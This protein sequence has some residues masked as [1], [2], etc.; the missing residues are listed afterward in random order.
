VNVSQFWLQAIQGAVIV[1]AIVSD[2]IIRTR[3][4]ARGANL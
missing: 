2:S 1:A 3:F 4:E